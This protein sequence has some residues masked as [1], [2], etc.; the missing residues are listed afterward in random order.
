MFEM[1]SIS[2]QQQFPEVYKKFY[3]KYDLVVSIP[4]VIRWWPNSSQDTNSINIRQKIPTRMYLW[5]KRKEGVSS[6]K[7]WEFC[8]FDIQ[9]NDFSCLK[10]DEILSPMKFTVIKKS[11]LTILWERGFNDSR[12]IW[13][14]C[15]QKRGYGFGFM[16]SFCTLF[17][18]AVMSYIEPDKVMEWDDGILKQIYELS[19]QADLGRW[20]WPSWVSQRVEICEW[21]DA[22][23][24]MGGL[25]ENSMPA[26]DRQRTCT[27][28]L[29][30]VNRLDI[31]D[32]GIVTLGFP[33]KSHDLKE[34]FTALK[35]ERVVLYDYLNTL[36]ENSWLPPELYVT[37]NKKKNTNILAWQIKFLKSLREVN[38]DPWS[39]RLQNN[40]LSSLW[41]V[42]LLE[43]IPVFDNKSLYELYVLFDVLKDSPEDTIWIVPISLA[44]TWWTF[45]F[46]MIKNKNRNTVEMMKQLLHDKWYTSSFFLFLSWRDGHS[47]VWLHIDQFISQWKFWSYISKTSV[48]IETQW[49]RIVAQH[50]D[51]ITRQTENLILDNVHKKVYYKWEKLT[52]KHLRSQSATVEIL[53]ILIKAQWASVHNTDFPISSYSKNKNEMIGKIIQ[54][55]ELLMK[56]VGYSL[57]ISC[58]W[59]LHNFYVMLGEGDEYFDVISSV[60]YR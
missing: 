54:P 6:M 9:K 17:A 18:S 52:H 33:Y 46:M 27:D 23:V 57:T 60:L 20:W 32:Y 26:R 29:W 36:L 59:T 10:K 16:G 7:V 37:P 55:L 34:K 40:V 24:Q 53:T 48:F 1:N 3:S 42:W 15:E 21:Y 28:L 8:F 11:F 2:L 4:N 5:V 13:V 14:L 19:I 51:A 47:D 38:Q 43:W 30:W 39:T 56:E 22:R 50:S 49:T 58:T 45:F 31:F 41:T 12:E 25:Y 35:K 44:D